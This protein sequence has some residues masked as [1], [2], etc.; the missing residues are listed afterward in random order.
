MWAS[1]GEQGCINASLIPLLTP[2]CPMEFIVAIMIQSNRIQEFEL[3]DKS[4]MSFFF[5]RGVFNRKFY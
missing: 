4:A 3:L 1:L 2:A 5:L